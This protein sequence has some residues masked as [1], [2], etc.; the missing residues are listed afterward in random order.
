M[1]ARRILVCA[2]LAAAPALP[3]A[4]EPRVCADASLSVEAEAPEAAELACRVAEEAKS[5]IG[6]CGLMQTRPIRIELVAALDHGFGMCLGAWDC[7]AGVIRVVAPVHLAGTVA[8][9]PPYSLFPTEVLF[10][11]LI[12]HELAHALLSQS[13]EGVDLAFADHEYV[14]AV[15]EL[16]TMAP[17]WREVYV[18]AAP[19][20]L[21]PRIGLI[22]PLIYGFEPRKFAVNA[23]QFFRAEPDGCA[24]IREIAAGAFSFGDLPP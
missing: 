22:S 21:P 18:A 16:E 9:E 7:E 19:V 20:G 8:L 5:V 15:M 14:A 12:A 23:W 2:V 3:A 24:R 1:D 10:R 4:A 17:E 13:G 11:A 6:A